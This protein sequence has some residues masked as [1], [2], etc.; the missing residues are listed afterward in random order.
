MAVIGAC[1]PTLRPLTLTRRQNSSK[2]ISD[3][4]RGSN[5]RKGK[6]TV[7]D[8]TADDRSSTASIAGLSKGKAHTG[9][10]EFQSHVESLPLQEMAPQRGIR[11]QKEFYG[12]NA[13]HV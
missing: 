10:T 1:L 11:V 12:G 2:I 8:I 13:D 7:T 3:Y 6:P 5:S 9:V 4:S